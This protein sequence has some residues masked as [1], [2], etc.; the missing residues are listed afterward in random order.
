MQH[1]DDKRIWHRRRWKADAFIL[2]LNWWEYEKM[3]RE[4]G[5]KVISTRRE[6]QLQSQW[7][8][9]TQNNA[10]SCDCVFLRHDLIHSCTPLQSLLCIFF[11]TYHGSSLR[12]TKTPAQHAVMIISHKQS[13]SPYSDDPGNK[14]EGRAPD[15]TAEVVCLCLLQYHAMRTNGVVEV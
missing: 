13:T 5:L 12:K 1:T 11:I 3:I 4:E 9:M 14:T 2:S 6:Q 7:R 15:G 10:Q 8:Y